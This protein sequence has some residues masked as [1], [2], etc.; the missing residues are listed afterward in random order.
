MGIKEIML[1]FQAILNRVR[2]QIF[3]AIA[4]LGVLGYMGIIK[5]NETITVGVITAIAVMSK[6]V[7][8]SDNNSKE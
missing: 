2:P 5:N 3:L 4:V 6:D 7:L 8:A 1:G